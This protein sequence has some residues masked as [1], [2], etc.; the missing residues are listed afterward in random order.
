M[1]EE[2]KNNFFLRLKRN[3]RL[4]IWIGTVILILFMIFLVDFTNLI[5]KILKIGLWWT[6][7]FII[8][9]TI[10]FVIRTYRLDLVFKG[11]D[12]DIS[13]STSYFSIGISFFLNDLF[14][15]KLGDVAK[16]GII[17]DH[18]HIKLSESAC[19]ITFERVMD[20]II[21]FFI[22][23]LALIYLYISG[24]G[25]SQRKT[26]LGLNLQFFLILGAIII[27]FIFFIFILLMYKTD[28]FLNLIRKISPR[29]SNF[30]TS[31]I[32][33][34]KMGIRQFKNSKKKLIIIIILS[35]LI[36]II[37]ALIGVMFLILLLKENYQA[38]I[39]ILLL[40]IMISYFSKA[41]PITPGGW[42]ISENVGT[43]FILIFYPQI[44]FREVLAIFII[45]HL[46]RSAYIFFYGGYSMLHYNFKLKE[47]KDI[48]LE[49]YR[50]QEK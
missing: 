13:I 31:F 45:E 43:L 27:V 40:A 4:L 38:H 17:K 29:I 20:F 41:F 23:S 28:L 50:D 21:L 11:L 30:L 2:Y 42:G 8:V 39:L 36:W 19:G 16:I 1:I 32:I 15:A 25:D 24:I 5:N 12:Q 47:L 49:I 9:Y 33:N 48:N 3:K 18:E 22:S 26:L 14:P 46:F 6:F 10:T 37:E 44:S 7:V 34:F 35:S